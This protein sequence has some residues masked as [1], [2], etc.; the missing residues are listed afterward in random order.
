MTNRQIPTSRKNFDALNLSI[1]SE[2]L[3][4]L[5]I[6][7]FGLSLSDQYWFCPIEMTDIS[8]NDLNYFQNSFRINL[9]LNSLTLEDKKIFSPDLSTNGNLPKKWII[10]DDVRYLCKGTSEPFHQEAINEVVASKILDILEVPHVDYFCKNN[11]SFCP[12]FIDENTEFVPAWHIIA[13]NKKLNHENN[14]SDSP[15]IAP[16]LPIFPPKFSAMRPL[17]FSFFE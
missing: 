3:T 5:T 7:N 1:N 10:I 14:Y 12:C 15:E 17:L 11:L 8:W 4:N 6:K 13:A 9:N 2:S 16:P